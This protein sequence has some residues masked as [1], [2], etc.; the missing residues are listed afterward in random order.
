VAGTEIIPLESV[1]EVVSVR[2]TKTYVSL[3]CISLSLPKDSREMMVARAALTSSRKAQF[4]TGETKL[5]RDHHLL[6]ERDVPIDEHK[7]DSLRNKKLI[8]AVGRVCTVFI[9]RQVIATTSQAKR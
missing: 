8:I 7:S 4:G 1:K 5:H 9:E 2:S 3:T 6:R